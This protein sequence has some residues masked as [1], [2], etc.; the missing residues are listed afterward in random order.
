MEGRIIRV[1]FPVHVFVEKN[2]TNEV[3]SNAWLPDR[4]DVADRVREALLR[5][6]DPGWDIV[7]VE[8]VDPK[9]WEREG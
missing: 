5:S 2:P 6:D 1:D 7:R 4:H 3:R 9:E 8:P